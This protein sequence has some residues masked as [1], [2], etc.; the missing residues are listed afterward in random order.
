MLSSPGLR[1][2]GSSLRVCVDSVEIDRCRKFVA[3][4]VKV[5]GVVIERVRVSLVMRGVAVGVRIDTRHGFV[6][7][8]HA[9]FESCIKRFVSVEVR[10]G[11]R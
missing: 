1:F 2:C 3:D 4:A 9:E 7:E 10:D 5:N 6:F 8:R 11:F